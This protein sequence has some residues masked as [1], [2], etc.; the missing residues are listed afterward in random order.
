MKRSFNFRAMALVAVMTGAATLVGCGN[1]P[2]APD[3]RAEADR[4]HTQVLSTID[5]YRRRDPGMERFFNNA[6]AFVVFPSVT[7]GALLVGG[8]HGEGEVYQ[9]GRLV[10]YADVS[11]ATVGAQAGGQEYSQ[12]IFFQDAGTFAQFKGGNL[13]FDAKAS[14]VAA[15]K[16]ASASANYKDGVVVFT[17][18]KGGL[19]AQAAIG[20]QKFRFIPLQEAAVRPGTG[21]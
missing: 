9:N 15:D 6:H 1:T 14:A 7:S 21:N 12:L 2:A 18:A 5:D 20:G 11:K 16:G 17:H 4:L 3:T 10:G 8:A 19:M 13:A